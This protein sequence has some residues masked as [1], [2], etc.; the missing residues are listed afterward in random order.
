ME[1]IS[2]LLGLEEETLAARPVSTKE[3]GDVRTAKTT[4]KKREIPLIDLENQYRNDPLIFNGINKIVQILNAT[5]MSIVGADERAVK[6]CED[7]L[8]GIGST[9]GSTD[10]ETLKETIFTH[11]CV[12]GSAYNEIIYDTTETKIVDLDFIDPKKMDY[13]KNENN[14]IALDNYS[15]PI[16]YVETLPMQETYTKLKSDP[17]PKRA[18]LQPNQIYLKKDRI[19]HYKLFIVGDGYYPIGL[20]EPIYKTSVRKRKLHEALANVFLRLGFPT[21]LAKVGDPSHEPTDELLNAVETEMNAA[22]YKSTLTIP[23]YVD[24]SILEPKSPNSLNEHLE[25]FVE[26]EIT[27]LGAPKVLITG[28]GEETNRATLNRQEALFKLGLKSILRRT[29]KTIETQI[30]SRMARLEGFKEV[31][32]IA[33]GELDLTELDSKAKRVSSLVKTGIIQPYQKL[34]EY[35]TELE[36]LPKKE[37][38]KK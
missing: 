5:K 1:S 28:S 22:T 33:W 23:S 31:P 9:G 17:L 2:Q 36:G 26:E 6:Y 3:E 37:P 29:G 4:P 8:D 27:G 38:E 20:I 7:F 25:S 18:V 16:G 14:K 30:F 19:A 34:A 32:K 11:Q 12:Y 24:I 10:W 15:N 13:L 21:R 35:F